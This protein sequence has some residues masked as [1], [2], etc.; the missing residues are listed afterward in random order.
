MTESQTPSEILLR[1][2][3]RHLQPGDHTGGYVISAAV[4]VPGHHRDFKFVLPFTTHSMKVRVFEG[5]LDAISFPLTKRG[6]DYN[7]NPRNRLLGLPETP[8]PVHVEPE[9]IAVYPAGTRIGDVKHFDRSQK[10]SFHCPKHPGNVFFSK[11]PY[12]S[13][14]FGDS[15]CPN[16]CDVKFGDHIVDAEY[17]PTRN[18]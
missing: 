17:R 6:D 18:G 16:D 11:D 14:W 2:P 4:T 13:T 5:D 8:A 9:P 12:A 10:V 7:P 15:W 1:V 3:A